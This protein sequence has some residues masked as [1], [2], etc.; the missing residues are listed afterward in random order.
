[1]SENKFKKVGH[2]PD[3]GSELASVAREQEIRKRLALGEPVQTEFTRSEEVVVT[4]EPGVDIDMI[5]EVSTV[6]KPVPARAEK[7]LNP[8][9]AISE[10]IRLQDQNTL[11]EV[12]GQFGKI[13]FRAVNVCIN[14]YGL[15]FIIHKD[16]MSYE[17]NINTEL[18]LKIGEDIYDVIYAGGFFTFRHIPF[19]FLSF[20]KIDK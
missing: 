13:S 1:M 11:V 17:P 10:M 2:L 7:P 3:K 5:R 15:A 20:I 19:N 8:L 9:E 6:V 4:E 16:H 14:D 12:Q 18:R